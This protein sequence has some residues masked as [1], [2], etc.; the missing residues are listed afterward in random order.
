GRRAMNIPAVGTGQI[1]VAAGLIFR[2]GLVLLAQR[3]PGPHLAG[4]WESPGGRREAGESWEACLA[5][6]LREELGIEVKVAGLY[7]RISHSYE[8]RIVEL[9]FFL[10]R[11][12][13]GEPRPLGCE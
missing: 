3:P 4:L 2:E 13:S 1:E 6:E 9:R 5:R 7:S 8:D 11:L 10:C 12:S